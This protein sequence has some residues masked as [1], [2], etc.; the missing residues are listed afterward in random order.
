MK[1]DLHEMLMM[2]QSSKLP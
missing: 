1:D 2:Q